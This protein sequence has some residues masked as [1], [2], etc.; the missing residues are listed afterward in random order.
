MKDATEIGVIVDESGSMEPLAKETISSF[1]KFL[2]EQLALPGEATMTVV[3]FSN[4]HRSLCV[5]TSIK[6]VKPLCPRTYKPGGYTALLDAVG[7]TI[8]AIGAKL[9]ALP[10]ADRPDKVIIVVLTDGEENAS[11][12]YKLAQIQAKVK[13]QQEKYNWQFIFMGANVDAFAVAG[14]YG[15]PLAHAMNYAATPSGVR[16][17][18]GAAGQSVSSHRRGGSSNI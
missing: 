16:G 11:T 7:S 5:N 17:A 14:S 3:L 9:A 13:E 4:K 15:V 18:F 10:E 1:N 12:E 6:E 8:D 2:S